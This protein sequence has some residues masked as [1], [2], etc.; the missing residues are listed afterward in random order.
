MRPSR[1]P[2]FFENSQD[3]HDSNLNDYSRKFVV[4]DP[5]APQAAHAYWPQDHFFHKRIVWSVVLFL[6]FAFIVILIRVG[7]LQISRGNH[8]RSM[9]EGNRIRVQTL[10][11]P[12]G[13]M[14]DRD[15]TLLVNN[16]PDFRLEVVAGDILRDPGALSQLK[17]L[18]Q[19]K[20]PTEFAEIEA[21]IADL[22]PYSFAPKIIRD[23]ISYDTALDI[24]L[25]SKG[26][27]G[28]HVVASASREY[29]GAPSLSH[30]VGYISKI[31]EEEL[32]QVQHRD[33]E[34]IDSIGKTGLEFSYEPILR[35][36]PGK[37]SIEVNAL[38]KE[39]EIL[40]EK[41]AQPGHNLVLTLDNDMQEFITERLSAWS[42]EKKFEAASVVVLEPATGKILSIVSVP[43]YDNNVFHR[44]APSELLR[45][46]FEDP[47]K[48]LIFR[49]IQGT[50]PSGST[51]KPF[52][53]SA[54]LAENII[55]PS[56]TFVSSGG[57]RIGEWFF[58]DW[59]PGGH[60]STNV[61][62]ALAQSVNTFFYMIGGGYEDFVGLG[63]ERMTAYARLFG[64][65]ERTGIDLPGEA[66][67]FLPTKAWKEATF[68]ERWYV[69]DTYHYAIGQG[70]IL[71]TP[72]QMASAYATL[73]NGGTLF[74]PFIVEK[75]IDTQNNPVEVF[76]PYALRAQFIHTSDLAAVKAGLRESVVSGS[77]RS[78]QSLPV[79][80]GG[81][82]GTAQFGIEGKTH[83]WF[84]G[85]APYDDPELVVSVTV[86]AGGQGNDTALP[87][88]KEIFEWYFAP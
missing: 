84:I 87:I 4:E 28:V 83:A 68:S 48:P 9:A 5:L 3:V 44:G 29:R 2:L 77:A 71:V 76:S 49:A 46:T 8:F 60:G 80:S 16:A 10:Q 74:R 53:A 72:L 75:I 52:V 78:L 82:T 56:T 66:Q 47:R 42:G 69:G 65:G 59:K 7:Y 40:A 45:A 38:G 34:L 57:I 1:F 22:A 85:F 35:G 81:K 15:G 24:M 37:K 51:F 6:C 62:K 32:T 33:Y 17:I 70:D 67:G 27:P 43:Y 61:T 13:V 14:Y 18:L 20:F 31:S 86:E 12:R 26:L 88:A 23:H 79:E 19:K 64:L 36:I 41:E 54:A 30:V 21:N 55:T 58:P 25:M 11:A 50:Y 63:V 73:V 39:K